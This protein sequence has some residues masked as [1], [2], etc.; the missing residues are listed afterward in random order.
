VTPECHLVVF[1]H[2]NADSFNARVC[3]TYVEELERRGH[4]VVLRDLYAIKFDPVLTMDDFEGARGGRG[5]DDVR[6]EQVHVTWADVITF[7]SP[8]WW[9]GWPAMLKGY[10][11]RVFALNFAYRYTPA[12]VEG[13]LRGKRAVII[14]SSGSTAE[15][16]VE[17]GKLASVRTAQ[18]VYTM[19]FCAV[20]MVDHLHFA[21]V[22]RRTPPERFGQ[23]LDEVRDFVQRHF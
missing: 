6:A 3:R 19:E 17:T 8:I 7:I 21:P 1:S 22:G 9:I 2:P 11:D 14:S 18:D 5:P 16:F 12:G 13:C 15:N 20:T 4:Q 23:M 10:V